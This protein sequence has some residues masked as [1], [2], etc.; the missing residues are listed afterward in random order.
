MLVLTGH[1]RVLLVSLIALLVSA[2]VHGTTDPFA[3]VL[4][5]EEQ[6][7]LRGALKELRASEELL[8]ANTDHEAALVAL[9]RT[10]DSVQTS[11]AKDQ[12]SHAQ[13]VLEGVLTKLD[14]LRDAHLLHAAHSKLVELRDLAR[15]MA[16]ADVARADALVAEGKHAEAIAIYKDVASAAEIPAALKR[17]V[18]QAMARAGTAKARA[19]ASGFWGKT[20]KS[21]SDGI[22]TLAG[23]SVFLLLGAALLWTAGAWRKRRTPHEETLIVLEDLTALAPELRRPGARGRCRGGLGR[24]SSRP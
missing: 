23:W 22:F 1:P 6:G 13:T 2:P 11:L 16:E 9:L 12:Y 15:G 24:N 3:S 14:P 4:A 18:T 19:E 20:W 8:K 7:D 21:A 10:F 5:R 17:R